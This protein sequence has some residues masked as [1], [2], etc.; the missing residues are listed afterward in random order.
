MLKWVVLNWSLVCVYHPFKRKKS[1]QLTKLVTCCKNR[2][3]NELL[4]VLRPKSLCVNIRPFWLNWIGI[5]KVRFKLQILV[6]CLNVGGKVTYTFLKKEKTTQ[7]TPQK[8]D[9]AG[10]HGGRV[11]T[12]K[13]N[14]K[15]NIT[16]TADYLQQPLK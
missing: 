3:L 6:L 2:K 8:D 7:A 5:I 16:L 15:I 13:Q 4:L 14:I 12:W 1:K 10:F 11:Y 9:S